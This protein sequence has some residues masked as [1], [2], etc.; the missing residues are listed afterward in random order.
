MNIVDESNG[1]QVCRRYKT[2]VDR[3]SPLPPFLLVLFDPA[4]ICQNLLHNCFLIVNKYF[5]TN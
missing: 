4:V 1:S 5:D 2:A 3:P